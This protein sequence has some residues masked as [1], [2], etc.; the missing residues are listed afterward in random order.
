MC[1]LSPSFCVSRGYATGSCHFHIN[2]QFLLLGQIEET[3]RVCPHCRHFS[4]LLRVKGVGD[5]GEE[6]SNISK[7]TVKSEFNQF[8]LK[9]RIYFRGKMEF[10][11]TRFASIAQGCG[12]YYHRGPGHLVIHITS[13]LNTCICEIFLTDLDTYG[14]KKRPPKWEQT[15]TRC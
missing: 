15:G 10:L 13:Y 8:F 5:R 2:N 1:P 7:V 14:K 3:R 6:A 12:W 4:F 11:L 9:E